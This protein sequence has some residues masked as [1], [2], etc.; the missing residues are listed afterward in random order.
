MIN[1]GDKKNELKIDGK[2]LLKRK[3]KTD[4]G[5]AIKMILLFLSLFFFLVGCPKI[6]DTND[7]QILSKS[8]DS[9]ALQWLLL[10]KTFFK[11]HSRIQRCIEAI[12][13]SCWF[14]GAI[15]E[16]TLNGEN[17]A[18]MNGLIRNLFSF[19]CLGEEFWG[20]KLRGSTSVNQHIRFL[21]KGVQR[22]KSAPDFRDQRA[23]H[24]GG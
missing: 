1:S 22:P 18:R 10:R 2:S 8:K 5:S 19:S 11:G 20:E 16:K 13:K 15:K 21:P 3:K 6:L 14:P 9:H 4:D 17:I 24:G 12:K 23:T 7:R